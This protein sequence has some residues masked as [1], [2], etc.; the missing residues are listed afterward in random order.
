M[1][2]AAAY[3]AH[4]HK[5]TGSLGYHVVMLLLTLAPIVI[6]SQFLAI[7]VDFG[8][9]HLG[10][11][12]PLGGILIAILVL[13][14]EGLTAFHAAL[15]NQLQRA[16]NV[17]LGSAL[18]TI[19]LTIPAVLAIG[20]C[21]G[22][23]VHLGLDRVDASLL[24]LTLFVSALTFGGTRTNVLQGTVHLLAV[25]GLYR[26]DLQ[27][28]SAARVVT[29]GVALADAAVLA[30]QQRLGALLPGDRLGLLPGLALGLEDGDGAAAP[31]AVT[32][33]PLSCATTCWFLPMAPLPA[34]R[35]TIVST[36]RE[37]E[38]P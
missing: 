4:R 34:G 25:R 11:P 32:A 1:V 31:S 30:V 36:S 28:V 5:A 6:L 24:V 15:A 3:A 2:T 18:A 7:I 26:A 21:T 19:G 38:A 29:V 8:I 35:S 10:V 16:V 13:S 23:E 22:Y 17:C 12:A 9:E 14:P 33:Q 27:P 20:L 37:D